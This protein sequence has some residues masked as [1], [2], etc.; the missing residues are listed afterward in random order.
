MAATIIPSMALMRRLIPAIAIEAVVL[1]GCVV[2]Y[3]LTENLFWIFLTVAVGLLFV[4][5]V[6]YM[7]FTH[8]AEWRWADGTPGTGKKP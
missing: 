5:W 2:A 8:R 4:I 6:L 7:V 3:T 1:C